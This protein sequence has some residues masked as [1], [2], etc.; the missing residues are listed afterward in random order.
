V[1]L[2]V[3]HAGMWWSLSTAVVCVVFLGCRVRSHV[4]AK[5]ETPWR[6][7]GRFV[8]ICVYNGGE[9]EG[10]KLD[11]V[12]PIFASSLAAPCR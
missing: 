10:V 4:F 8:V 6:V 9:E 5:R 1:C 7:K 2:Y 3:G 12:A 11:A